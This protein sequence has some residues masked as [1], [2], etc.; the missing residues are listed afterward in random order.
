VGQLT[1]IARIY[2]LK[3]AKALG[4]TIPPSIWCARTDCR[5]RPSRRKFLSAALL[6]LN[7]VIPSTTFA[8]TRT[9]RIGILSPRPNSVYLPGLRQRFGA[10]G[11]VEGKN[12]VIDYRS[13]DGDIARFPLL[14]RDLVQT[15]PDLIFAI[16]PEQAA[17][18]L[19]EAKSNIPVVIIAVDYD[20]EKAGIISSLRRPGGNITGIALVQPQLAA[21]RLE[22]LR[23]AIP[24]AKRILVLT[25]SF[26]A[27]QL[28]AVRK[29]ATLLKVELVVE[30]F[31][32]PPYDLRSAFREAAK[33][34]VDAVV[35]LAS[36][37]LAEQMVPIL[38]AAT[39]YRLP[40]IGIHVHYA[41]AGHL[42]SYGINP[43]T[44][45]IRAAD[46]AVSILKGAKPADLPVEQ[47]M[48]F[49]LVVNLKT[50]KVLG[51][52]FPQTILV[53]ADRVIQ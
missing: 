22:L 47:P 42:L 30:T 51:I 50:A 28:E 14:A 49:E 27:E 39:K 53:R 43:L 6:A 15:A 17:R 11:Y 24:R 12:L 3:T 31:A 5:T 52:T 26:S 10:L 38:E 34:G 4:H 2:G 45:V 40:S 35:P 13:A 25:D 44:V 36:P 21:K 9:A 37:V 19:L 41:E 29:A 7:A 32:A 23:E 46:I 48:T 16:G 1:T 18:A 33:I 20:P 8:Q